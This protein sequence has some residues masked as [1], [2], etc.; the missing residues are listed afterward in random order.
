MENLQIDA[1][2]QDKIRDINGV[3]IN[4]DELVR[5]S[6]NDE[7]E[8]ARLLRAAT[9]ISDTESMR[10]AGL[11]FRNRG[12]SES[13]KTIDGVSVRAEIAQIISKYKV[14]IFGNK[15]ALVMAD[16]MIPYSERIIYI[17]S[18]NIYITTRNT[19]M[20][21]LRTGVIAVTDKNIYVIHKA[22]WESGIDIFPVS[23]LELVGYK[24]DGI[25]GAKIDLTLSNVSINFLVGYR[26]EFAERLYSELSELASCVK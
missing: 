19:N 2:P 1:T 16:K 18:S 12:L 17:G 10:L 9:G 3:S 6:G 4:V 11:A 8:M 23:N 24:A 15:K 25:N 5:Q 13:I 14:N 22:F 7:K 21:K 26:K 20:P